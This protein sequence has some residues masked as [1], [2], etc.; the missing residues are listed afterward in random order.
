MVYMLHGSS[1]EGVCPRGSEG[2]LVCVVEVR[3]TARAALCDGL[4]E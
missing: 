2:V 4:E 3:G 1:D